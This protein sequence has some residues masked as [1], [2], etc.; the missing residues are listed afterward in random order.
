MNIVC[1]ACGTSNRIPQDRSHLEGK[2]GKCKHALHTF[3]PA[4]LDDQTAP[5]YLER[6]ELPVLVDFWASWC[7]PCKMMKPIFEQTAAQSESLL[8]AKVDTESAPQ[9]S[10]QMNI[11]SIPTLV[12][13]HQGKEINR[14]SGA[15]QEAQLKQWILQQMQA[16]F[17]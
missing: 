4:E 9:F 5:H 11:R 17:N 2:C 7:G 14:I 3:T 12:L 10:Q 13:F 15:L 1:P 16:L 8:F 6:N